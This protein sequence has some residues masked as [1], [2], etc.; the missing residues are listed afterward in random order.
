MPLPPSKR[1]GRWPT[2]S[3][4]IPKPTFRRVILIVLDGVGCGELP[5]AAAYGDEGSNTVGNIAKQIPLRVPTL[6]SLGLD[7]LVQLAPR[8]EEAAENAKTA[9]DAQKS[10]SRETSAV[11]AVLAVPSDRRVLGAYGRMAEASAGKDSVTGHWE[12][13]GIILDRAFPTFPDGFAPEIIAEFSRLTGRGVLGNKAASGT[14]IID[15]LGPEHMRTGALIVYTSADSVFQIAAH[16]DIVP[17]PELYRACEIAYRLVGEGLGVGRVIARPFVGAPGAFKRTA[18]RHDYALPPSA[19][20]LLDRAT[21]ASIP[22]VAIGKIEDL[23]AGRGVTRGIHTVSDDDGMDH[24]AAQMAIVERGLIFTNLVDFDAQYGHRNDV[25]GY[26]ANLERFDAR[27][28]AILPQLR[29]DDLLV[30]TADHGNDP[31][32]SSTDHAREYVPLLIAGAR[33]RSGNNLG[34]RKTFADVGQTL[35]EMFGVGP[36]ANGTSF[37]KEITIGNAEPAESAE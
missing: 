1:D 26:A 36:M 24:V 20:T 37:L 19:E 14:G 15:E 3:R 4:P 5:D 27:L 21:A 17:I 25:A 31:T 8:P 2:T 35:A 22:V 29:D 18:N 13:M 6:R 10:S 7:R 9:E 32:T 34:T 30:V 33:V 11:S 28:A 23:F 12:M 16:E